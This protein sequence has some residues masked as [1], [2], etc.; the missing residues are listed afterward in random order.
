MFTP[1][2]YQFSIYPKNLFREKIFPLEFF[3]AEQKICTNLHEEGSKV[4]P[5]P[6]IVGSIDKVTP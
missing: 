1:R 5:Q 4:N 2:N 6:R 3:H